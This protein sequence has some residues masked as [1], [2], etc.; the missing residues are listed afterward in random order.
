MPVSKVKNVRVHSEV[1]LMVKHV[2]PVYHFF[3]INTT[4]SKQQGLRI[5]SSNVLN[6]SSLEIVHEA[7][8][9]DISKKCNIV[10]G[11]NFNAHIPDQLPR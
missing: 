4:I 8:Y 5:E 9:S 7:I 1:E 6:P 2:L 11:A 10:I 3:K